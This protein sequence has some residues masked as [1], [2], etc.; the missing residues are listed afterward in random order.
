MIARI[1]HLSENDDAAS[2]VDS[3]EWANAN[4]V[5]LIVPPESPLRTELDFAR[6]A[7]AAKNSGCE[8]AI[9]SGNRAIRALANEVGLPA[10][11]S[12]D[13]AATREWLGSDDVEPITRQVAPRRFQPNSLRRFFPSRNWLGM[14]ASGVIGLVTLGVM[15]LA[16][17]AIVPTATITL[18]ADKTNL[19][20]I[21]PVTLDPAV[22]KPSAATRVVPAQRVDV[23]VSGAMTVPATGKKDVSK[24]KARGQ[25]TFFNILAQPYTVPKNTVVR[26]SATGNVVRFITLGEVAL[27]PGGQGTVAIEAVEEGSSGNVPANTINVIEGVPSIA[28]R[29]IN[30]NGTGGGGGETVSAVTNDDFARARAALRR[31]LVA[32]ASDLMLK[33]D[34]VVNNGLHVL[35]DTMFVADV[36]DESFDRFVGEQA[37]NVTLNMRLQI[38]GLAIVPTDL[39]VIARS[40]LTSLVPRGFDLLDVNTERGSVAEEGGSEIEYFVN[41]S[42][43][44]GTRIDEESVK[45]LVRGKAPSE[46][47]KLLSGAYPLKSTPK[48]TMEPEWLVKLTNRIPFAP[49][50]INVKVVRE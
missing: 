28:A 32:Q 29:A 9:V 10:F 27:A 37:E 3:L 50:R 38:A 46:A 19:S 15:A 30:L 11:A 22:T 26:S 2:A 17:A 31:Q 49:M 33:N 47:L 16:L 48:I 18:T 36:Q 23:V 40:A 21:V 13:D 24:F 41:A 14:A 8:T 44:A 4:R 12:M 39:N 1:I 45:K 42:G 7:R 6:I 25:V 20:A 43:I 5:A 34:K 35:P